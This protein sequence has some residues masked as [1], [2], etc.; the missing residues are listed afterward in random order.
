[1]YKRQ[2]E[3]DWECVE[4]ILVE[5]EKDEREERKALDVCLAE[6]KGEELNLIV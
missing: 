6:D 3:E 2:T 1:M 5:I 4:G